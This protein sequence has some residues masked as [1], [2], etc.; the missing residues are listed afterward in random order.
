VCWI[1]YDWNDSHGRVMYIQKLDD[2]RYADNELIYDY[3]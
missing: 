2:E 3:E 1:A